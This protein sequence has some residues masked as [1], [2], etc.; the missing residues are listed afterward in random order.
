MKGKI[1]LCTI[2]MCYIQAGRAQDIAES[3]VKIGV[4]YSPEISSSQLQYQAALE[5]INVNTGLPDPV[6]SVGYFVSPVETRVGPQR[7]K[8]S[9]LQPLPWF[10]TVESGR[11]VSSAQAEAI[12]FKYLAQISEYRFRVKKSWFD[13]NYL[14][15]IIELSQESHVLLKSIEQISLKKFETS[16]GK[17]VDVLR[18]RLAIQELESDL[19]IF[20]EQLSIASQNF[21]ILLNQ[22]RDTAIQFEKIGSLESIDIDLIQDS[23]SNNPNLRSLK[24]EQSSLEFEM[25]SVKKNNAPKIG[26]GLEY[27]FVDQLPVENL[28][29]NGKDIFM[30]M[31]SVSL[32]IFSK[33]KSGK[34]QKVEITRQSSFKSEEALLNQLSTEHNNAI[35]KFERSS[36]RIRLYET[37]LESIRQ[38][39]ELTSSQYS[40][41]DSAVEE[42]LELQIMLLDYEKRIARNVADQHVAI[43]ELEKIVF[44]NINNN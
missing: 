17:M 44:K 23:I 35:Y 9:L 2:L 3:Y 24:V 14:N 29:D 15:E 42:L 22:D 34:L 5:D 38:I 41:G 19:E 31:V 7:F 4:E 36:R 40:T 26:I 10:G 39:I 18:V 16:E 28:Q 32:P 43:S 27:A 8:L 37:Q 6:F 30:P 12:Y 33:R 13:L 21:N 1:F 25:T 20:S 11:E